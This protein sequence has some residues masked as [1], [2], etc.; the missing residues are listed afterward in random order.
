[1]RGE[2]C[3]ETLWKSWLGQLNVLERYQE[4]LEE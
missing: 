1:M 4:A 3:S 2:N